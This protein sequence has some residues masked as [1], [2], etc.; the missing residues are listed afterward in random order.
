ME[1]ITNGNQKAIQYALDYAG[2]S[3]TLKIDADVDSKII[4]EG[5]D[6]LED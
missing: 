6:K 2:Y 1:N 4:F 3:S 5:E